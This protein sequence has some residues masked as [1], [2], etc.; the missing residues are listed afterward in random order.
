MPNL[1]LW[2]A[3]DPVLPPIYTEGLKE[4]APDVEL[5]INKKLGH[6]LQEEDPKWCADHIRNFIESR[7]G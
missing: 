1:V 6:F 2:G 3:L 7:F 4:I 5:H